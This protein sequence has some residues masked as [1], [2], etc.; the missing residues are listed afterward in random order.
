M[1]MLQVSTPNLVNKN[2]VIFLQNLTDEAS[3]NRYPRKQDKINNR[4]NFAE[5]RSNMKIFNEEA[6]TF[7]ITAL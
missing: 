1:H 5:L 3:I 7:A 4:A 2:T 6:D